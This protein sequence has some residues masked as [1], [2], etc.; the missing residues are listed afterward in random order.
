[1]LFHSCLGVGISLEFLSGLELGP[2]LGEQQ[3]IF[4]SPSYLLPVADLDVKIA[5]EAVCLI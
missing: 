2:G 3:A 1:M 5:T 4:H